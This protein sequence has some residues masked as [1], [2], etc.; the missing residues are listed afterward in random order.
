MSFLSQYHFKGRQ[1]QAVIDPN[2][3]IAVTAGAGA[4]LPAALDHGN[5]V[6]REGGAGDARTDTSGF[7]SCW[8]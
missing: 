1:E 2:P 4:G 7:G 8:G 6:H 5:H 3:A